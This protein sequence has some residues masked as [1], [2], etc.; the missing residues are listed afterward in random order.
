ME[1]NSLHWQHLRNRLSELFKCEV[2]RT[3]FFSH[4]SR[5][6]VLHQLSNVV[7]LIHV[8]CFHPYRVIEQEFELFMGVAFGAFTAR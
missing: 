8:D 4:I 2:R 6:V 7:S 1:M 3:L 5:V